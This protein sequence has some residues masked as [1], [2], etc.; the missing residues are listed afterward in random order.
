MTGSVQI[1]VELFADSP[2]GQSND[3]VRARLFGLLARAFPKEDEPR[4]V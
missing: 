1:A 3:A 4:T 2:I